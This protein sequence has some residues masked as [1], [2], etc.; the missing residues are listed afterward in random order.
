MHARDQSQDKFRAYRTTPTSKAKALYAPTRN[1]V[2]RLRTKA[3]VQWQLTLHAHDCK[4][5]GKHAAE[6]A[7]LSRNVQRGANVGD[8]YTVTAYGG[9]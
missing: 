9:M 8:M 6:A 1:T 2:R 5:L 3:H 7:M 4:W